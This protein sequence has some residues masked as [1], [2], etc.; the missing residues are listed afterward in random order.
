MTFFIIAFLSSRFFWQ[1]MDIVVWNGFVKAKEQ[2]IRRQ[3]QNAMKTQQ[4]QQ[5]VH[6]ESLVSRTPKAEQK[7]LIRKLKD[8]Q[9]RKLAMLAQQYEHSIAEM[10]EHQNVCLAGYNSCT[11]LCIPT[12]MFYCLWLYNFACIS[13]GNYVVLSII[14]HR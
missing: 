11:L 10:V 9:N 8:D 6:R 3:F 5:K 7:E 2:E 12:Y 14:M 1:L 4:K 13:L